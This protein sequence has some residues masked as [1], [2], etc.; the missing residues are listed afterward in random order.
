M[1][2]VADAYDRALRRPVAIKEML[3]TS[4]VDLVRFEREARITAKL[5]H[6]GIVPIHDAGRTAD[7]TPFYVMRRIDGQ[8]LDQ[9]IDEKLDV[10]LALIPN[11]L[12]A[13]DAVAFAHAR[14]VVHRDIKPS[15]ILIGP[16]GETLVIDW[17][18]ARELSTDEVGVAVPVSD[19]KLTRAGTVAG[20]PGFMSPEQ[21]RGETVDA[22]ADVFALGATL[23]FVLA[24]QAPYGSASATEMVDLAGAGR[25][26]DWRRLPRDVPADLRAIAEKAMAMASAQRYADASALAADLRRFVTGNLVGAYDYGIA[27]RLARFVRRHRAAVAVAAISATIVVAIAVLALRRI[28]S[29]RDDASAAGHRA[30]LAADRLLVQHARALADSDPVAA[31]IALRSIATDPDIGRAAWTAAAAAYLHGIP[32][33]FASSGA[34]R[35]EISRDSRRALV[36]G[37]KNDTLTVVDLVAHTAHLVPGKCPDVSTA[38][39]LGPDHAVCLG[40]PSQIIDLRTGTTRSL[41]RDVTVVVGD[42]DSRVWFTTNTGHVLELVDP[43]GAPREI[44]AGVDQFYTTDDLSV[45]L[46]QHGA[47][48]ELRSPAG[49]SVVPVEQRDGAGSV[50]NDLVALYNGTTVHVW[51]RDGSKLVDGWT[52]TAPH[53]LNVVLSNSVAYVQ[54]VQGLLAIK[55]GDPGMFEAV[56]GMLR[57]TSHGFVQLTEDGALRVHDEWGWTRIQRKSSALRH[58]DVSPDNRILVATTAAGEIL[59]WDLRGTAPLRVNVDRAWI[60]AAL[61][62]RAVWLTSPLDGVARVDA[63]TGTFELALAHEATD[64]ALVDLEERWVAAGAQDGRLYI[65]DRTNGNHL[66]AVDAVI[67]VNDSVGITTSRP[68]G[69]VWRWRAGSSTFHLVGDFGKALDI[70]SANH[71]WVVGLVDGELVRVDPMQRVER[72]PAP[73]DVDTIQLAPDGQLWILAGH[74]VWGWKAGAFALVRVPTADPIDRISLGDHELVMTAPREITTLVNGVTTVT[75]IQAGIPVYVDDRRALVR[76]DRN[77]LSMF[78]LHSGFSFTFSNRAVLENVLASHDRVAA[79][80]NMSS[81]GAT[82]TIWNVNVPDEPLALEAWLGTITNA[83]SVGASEIYTWP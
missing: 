10:R 57:P 63:R 62:D 56:F 43:D 39:W 17:G 8:P 55:H 4:G 71:D 41:G 75:P 14:G 73:P 68:D 64:Y 80:T 82:L 38:S 50:S 51:Q 26:P 54:T 48:W 72:L 1:G 34:G 33:G 6:P 79:V 59:E 16:F 69:T 66:A 12:A 58:G 28:I 30:Q 29:E 23:F 47:Q 44:A 77:E 45:A 31:V 61:T 21:A 78:D 37:W 46:L 25:E 27:A 20:T 70:L 83:Q 35:V 36:A 24:G 5:E 53:I 7:G 52:Y 19:G 60:P 13:C 49:T 18:I 15:N 67:A 74:V 3:T 42:R 76:S 2:R 40:V 32:F 81:R 9:L 65:A 22:R 11:V